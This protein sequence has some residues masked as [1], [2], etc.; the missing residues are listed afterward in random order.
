LVEDFI[1]K[2]KIDQEF[3]VFF[4]CVDFDVLILMFLGVDHG[5]IVD[6]MIVAGF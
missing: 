2:K 5:W 1:L 3:L 4:L 6:W